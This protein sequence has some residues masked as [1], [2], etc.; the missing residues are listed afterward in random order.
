MS[1]IYKTHIAVVNLY[2]LN[3]TVTKYTWTKLL[4]M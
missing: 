1:N 4:E 3:K 2:A